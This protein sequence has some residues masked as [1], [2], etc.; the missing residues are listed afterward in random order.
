LK[1]PTL[2]F[3]WQQERLISSEHM[4]TKVPKPP[5]AR[6]LAASGFALG[7]LIFLGAIQYAVT[8]RLL[9]DNRWLARVNVIVQELDATVTLLTEAEAAARHYA[10]TGG[11]SYLQS[12]EQATEEAQGHFQKLGELTSG[13]PAQ[14]QMVSRLAPLMDQSFR[15]LRQAVEL[16]R[17]SGSASA[18]K[19]L[20]SAAGRNTLDDA[21]ALLG[22]IKGEELR[23]IAEKSKAA[24]TGDR[25]TRWVILLVSFGAIVVV[26]AATLIIY[27]DLRA[28]GGVESELAHERDLL[29]ILMDNIPDSIYFKDK[30]SRF[31]RI[32]RA[33]AKALGVTR[34]EDA[35]GKTD[36]DFFTAE[37]AQ[38]ALADEQ[39]ILRTGQPVI[40]KIEEATRPGRPSTWF[41]TTK[42]VIR[43]ARGNQVGTFGLSR[44]VTESRL[45]EEERN[46]FFSLSSDLLCVAG[47]DG[48]LQ[49]VN[50]GWTLL[51]VAPEELLHQP[52]AA[53]VHPDD[54]AAVELE[55]QKLAQRSET[56]AFE[57]RLR[58]KDGSYR[59]FVWNAISIVDQQQI[60][61]S[62]REVTERRRSDQK[63]AALLEAAPDAMVVV[64][65]EGE[66]V[67]VNAQVEK[68]FGYRRGEL[69]ERQMELLVPERFRSQGQGDHFL[70]LTQGGLKQLYGLRKNGAEFPVE[71]SLSPIETE[72]GTVVC[73]VIRDITER[74]QAEQRFR[75]LLEGA[76]DA[77]I[78]VDRNGW[79]VLVN[80]Q[81][82]KLF[83]YSREEL[84][85]HTLEMLV[86]ERFRGR[87]RGHRG[88]FF[89]DPKQR[90]M[91][92]AME[93]YGL[94]KDGSEFPVE[95]S[96]SP[97]ET[98]TG[99]LVSSTIRD[100]TERKQFEGALQEKNV[101]LENANLAKDR[102]LASMSHELRTPLNA[103]I[104]FTGTLLMKLPGPLT[105]EQSKQLQTISSSAKHL[106]SLISD[107]LDLAKIGSGKVTLNLEPVSCQEV[108]E[109][110]C[111]TLRPMAEKKNLA[112][113][114]TFPEEQ[115]V[116]N[117]DR[118]ALSQI[119]LNL[120]NNAV[121]FTE[122]GEVDIILGRQEEGGRVWTQLSVHDTGIG[123]L[124]E[125][126]PKL[127]QPFTQVQG[128]PRRHEGTGLGL[129]LS[130][131]LAG[132]LG[133]HITFKSG[134]GRG[135]TFTLSLPEG[136]PGDS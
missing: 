18:R 43:D 135:S 77:I 12:L 120:A 8:R 54:R 70:G 40:G 121:K 13:S 74:R 124:A 108:V 28:R 67:L 136:Q 106:L 42:M 26:T 112:L 114:V 86:P 47:F 60:Y 69:L 134:Y 53:F 97:L 62:G 30:A 118:R 38:R 111:S 51:G 52:Y 4:K 32:N 105:A 78:V 41:S 98:E 3:R 6:L 22:E 73:S 50:P 126:Q 66:I 87:H 79:I 55:F 44:D 92:A 128:N 48:R 82:E 125:D 68:M 37:H 27:F 84:L 2:I 25:F 16:H 102:F 31:T 36:L 85:T 123:I 1:A 129:Q 19:A 101:E 11:G 58:S 109:E 132:L 20:L 65:R 104:G 130:Q 81:A 103:I 63:F 119:L 99:I 34:P 35:I 113:N 64:N 110:V 127:F 59:W 115:I 117:T 100:I 9:E 45:A 24:E 131:K 33:Q 76:P 122:Q 10:T 15:V 91:G 56:I 7:F 89:G 61:A 116:L 96:L 57:C 17:A 75:A 72:E 133:G 49:R 29:H 5:H 93:L 83:G 46:R 94:R 21:R 95:I 90:P 88:R 71:I 107:L 23:L 80:S 14:Q 39:E